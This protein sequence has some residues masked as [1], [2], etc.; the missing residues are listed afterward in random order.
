MPV[1]RRLWLFCAAALLVVGCRKPIPPRS[2]WTGS[3]TLVDQRELPFHLVLD[4]DGPHPTGLFVNGDERTPI[5][6]IR[7]SGDSLS[8]ILS[9]YRAAM[10]GVWDGNEWRGR[11]YRYRADTIS[12]EFV[13][14]PRAPLTESPVPAGHALVG[15]FR[16][17]RDT[18]DGADSSQTAV[19]W[20]RRD[21][22]FGTFIAPDG[23]LGLFAGTQRGDHARL[24][25][26]NGWQAFLMEL[27]RTGM[28]WTAT[29]YARSGRPQRFRL[30]PRPPAATE[31][32]QERGAT[33]KDPKAP[34]RFVG[35]ATSGDTVRDTDARFRGKALL[36]D[37]MGTWCHNC[38]DAAP[39]LQ[40]LARTFGPDGLEVVGL[41][42]ELSDDPALARK[43]LTLYQQRYGITFPVLFCGS[44]QEANVEARVR[45]Q[46]NEFGGY[47]TT[48]FI[49]RRG[50]V[51]EIHLG[52]RGPGT[53]DGYQRQ[54]QQYYDSVRRLLK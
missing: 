13:A 21:S 30:E 48:F 40:E 11:F 6:E 54:V 17:F 16:V 52:F 45:S 34:F 18:K 23:D 44:T 27:D 10:L 32:V 50:R 7:L 41:S 46:V 28:V 36:I 1:R 15:T 2:D 9:E 22:T 33:M 14:R 51:R 4:F 49:D 3:L 29:L 31:V 37:I 8:F 53:G 24:S 25:R 20:M 26:F 5:P 38:M 12:N 35:I 42:F 47:P 39:L 19:F 43:N